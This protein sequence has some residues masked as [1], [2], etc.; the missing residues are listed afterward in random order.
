VA[1]DLKL[2]ERVRKTLGERRGV[3]EKELFGGLGFMV[4]GHMAC[5]II[6]RS[7]VVRV[8]PEQ[9]DAAMRLDGAG[10]FKITGK[11]SRGWILVRPGVLQSE[12]SLRDW[13]DR[14]VHFARSL[15]P[16]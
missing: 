9:H 2:A 4:N 3:S 16:K 7:L 8:G 14:G 5:G 13:V 10:P 6:K 15:P 12:A 1:Y 11:S